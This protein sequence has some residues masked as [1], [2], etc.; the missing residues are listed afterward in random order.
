MIERDIT[1]SVKRLKALNTSLKAV[2]SSY[3]KTVKNLVQILTKDSIINNQEKMNNLNK[4]L[5]SILNNEKAL[6]LEIKEITNNINSNI[7]KKIENSQNKIINEYRNVYKGMKITFGLD[8]RPI[9]KEREEIYNNLCLLK[10]MFSK[11]VN[12]ICIINDIGIVDSK[13]KEKV[14]ELINKTNIFE[15]ENNINQKLIKE[16]ENYLDSLAKKI[17]NYI[18]MSGLPIIESKEIED[19]KWVVLITDERECNLIID[20]MKILKKSNQ[21][22]VNVW[23]IAEVDKSLLKDFKRYANGT[24]YFA[25]YIPKLKE[26]EAK[27]NEIKKDLSTL[28]KRAKVKGKTILEEDKEEYQLLNKEYCYLVSA[29]VADDLVIYNGLKLEP[30]Y[31]SNYKETEKELQLLR[32]NATIKQDAGE[33]KKRIESR[34]QSFSDMM[35]S[36]HI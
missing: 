13:D 12:E 19:K 10:D 2:G 28:F 25:K 20:I 11:P 16:L 18:G 36:M 6:I 22:L 14:L 31:L 23:N 17:S 7:I 35:S 1:S 30:K 34:V 33:I 8:G 5:N 29:Q 27:I 26:N 32:K 21:D 24:K 9:K 15:L 4:E 3:E